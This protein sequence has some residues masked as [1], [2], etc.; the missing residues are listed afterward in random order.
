MDNAGLR[1]IF[2]RAGSIEDAK[3][4]MP[5]DSS[6]TSTFGFVRFKNRADAA[7]AVEMF[8][9]YK[10]ENNYLKVRFSSNKNQHQRTDSNSSSSIVDR[11]NPNRISIK[12]NDFN[13]DWDEEDRAKEKLKQQKEKVDLDGSFNSTSTFSSKAG[14][15]RGSFLK[16]SQKSQAVSSK[17]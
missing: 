8:T 3:I 17:K 5:K 1:N 10:I 14:C 12:I 9:H 7:K 4:C 15:G 6:H 16:V 2:T 13:E 11:S